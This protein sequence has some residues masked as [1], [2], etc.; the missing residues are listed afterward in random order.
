MAPAPIR[1]APPVEVVAPAYVEEPTVEVEIR[2]EPLEAESPDRPTDEGLG[3]DDEDELGEV[4]RVMLAKEFSGL[5]Q[6]RW[7]R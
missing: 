2:R 5:L 4:D 3:G 7:G 6:V 1:E